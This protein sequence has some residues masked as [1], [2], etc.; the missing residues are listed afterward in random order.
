MVALLPAETVFGMKTV[1]PFCEVA[2]YC[3]TGAEVDV[4]DDDEATLTVWSPSS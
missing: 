3:T 4:E 2:A 1:C